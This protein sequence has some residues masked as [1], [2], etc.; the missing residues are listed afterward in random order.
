M[1]EEIKNSLEETVRNYL[2]EWEVRHS[3]YPDYLW[4]YTS[5]TGELLN[6]VIDSF[7]QIII[8]NKSDFQSG[9]LNDL[10]KLMFTDRLYSV[11][12]HYL[13]CFKHP[14]FKEE[15]EWR[16]IYAPDLSQRMGNQ[17]QEGVAKREIEY[18]ESGGYIVPYLKVNIAEILESNKIDNAASEKPIRALRLPF[19]A[20]I[21]G[22]GL[23]RKLAQASLN[24]FI[25]RKG[26]LGTLID[27]DHSS[28]P[29]RNM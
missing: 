2:Y 14:T 11:F 22:P 8:D 13:S 9:N 19:D 7:S 10:T 6:K 23:D 4:H 16:F 18:R 15:K 20:I 25:L 27:I 28:V 21:S 5:I 26:Y 29:V 17:N 24:S 3:N 1:K 12:Y